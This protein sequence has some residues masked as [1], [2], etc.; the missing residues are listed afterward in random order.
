MA[1]ATV[2]LSFYNKIEV[3]KLVLASLELQSENDF[4]V[5]I[6]DDGSGEEV[7]KL[8]KSYIT[9]STLFIKHCWHTDNGWMKNKILNQAVVEAS[10]EYF[11]FVD[12]DCLL[13]KHF[14]REHL[15]YAEDNIIL[16]GRRV[17]LSNRVSNKL[18]IERIKKGY[19]GSS[20]A[21]D[22]LLD[23]PSGEVKDWEQGPY[24]G[25]SVLADW[26]NRKKKGILGSNF[27]IHKQN[28]YDV[29]GFDERFEYPAAGEDSDIENRLL[30]NGC[31]V[32]TVRNRAIQYHIFHQELA[33]PEHRL[34]Y[35][36]ENDE[37][38]LIYTPHGIVQDK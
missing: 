16:T 32:K 37:K 5:I 33:R 31:K 13:H 3:L 38:E 21:L 15:K 9:D 17:N 14:V 7:V 27:S 11:I 10:S 29:N 30:R 23:L 8:I 36:H 26:L 4:E 24:L 2:I 28:F 6:A 19:L 25:S 1:K 18:S 22:L 34:K 12:A 20:I 35:L